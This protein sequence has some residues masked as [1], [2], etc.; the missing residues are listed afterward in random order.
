MWKI[1][2]FIFWTSATTPDDR[3]REFPA[4]L[5]FLLMCI[6]YAKDKEAFLCLTERAEVSVVSED[7]YETIAEYLGEPELL[8]SEAGTEGGRDMCK[9]IRELVEDGEKRE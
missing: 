9:A 3:L 2:R 5:C 4:E 6:K 7:T 1:I 8:E